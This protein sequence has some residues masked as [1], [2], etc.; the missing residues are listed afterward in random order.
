MLLRALFGRKLNTQLSS[1]FE[2]FFVNFRRGKGETPLAHIAR[3]RVTAKKVE[4]L[5]ILLPELVLSWMH[6]G[7]SGVDDAG[8][9]LIM[10]QV[11]RQ[12]AFQDMGGRPGD[13][14][15]S[16]VHGQIS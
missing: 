5:K 1:D 16:R 10:S 13:H 12:V 8:S 4:E 9:A 14:V 11:G 2:L 15:R 7:R 6:L 3:F